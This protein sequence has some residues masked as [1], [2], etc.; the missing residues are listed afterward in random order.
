[1]EIRRKRQVSLLKVV[2]LAGGR[3]TRLKPYTHVLPKPL[4][5]V[6]QFPILEIVIRSLARNGLRDIIICTGYMSEIIESFCGRGERFGVKIDYSREDKPLGTAGSLALLGDKLKST[7]MVMNGDILVAL[8]ICAFIKSHMERKA[9]VT[10]GL[11]K[12]RTETKLGVV[13]L[14]RSMR[15]LD[16]VEKPVHEYMAS[17]GIHLMQPDVLDYIKPGEQLD[18]PDLIMR[19][20]K[21]GKKVQGFIIDG[22]WLHLSRPDDFEIANENWG[23]IARE[24]KLEDVLGSSS[25]TGAS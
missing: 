2:I 12:R 5:P 7:F 11:K 15:V 10:I 19:L 22:L 25:R 24:M 18:V 13:K 21:R 20:I 23:R 4:M 16:Y 9:L 3:G 1:M 14:S 8:D 17:A 6:D